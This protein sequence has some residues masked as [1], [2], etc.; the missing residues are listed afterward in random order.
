MR[1][2]EDGALGPSRLIVAQTCATQ[3]GILSWA[4]AAGPPAAHGGA[5]QAAR[6]RRRP[7]SP[8][9]PCATTPSG[10][11]DL[12][13]RFRTAGL[14]NVSASAES[15]TPV[16]GFI[17]GPRTNAARAPGVGVQLS[18]RKDAEVCLGGHTASVDARHCLSERDHP[19]LVMATT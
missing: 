7:L 19:E 5:W 4:S 1:E 15:P 9:R 14:P 6:R 10:Q 11:H 2:V 16:G 17:G 18:G 8:G 12:P 13:H 3:A